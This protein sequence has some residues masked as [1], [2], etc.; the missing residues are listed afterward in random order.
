MITS[1]ELKKMPWSFLAVAALA[2]AR[3]VDAGDDQ[4]QAVLDAI[5]AILRGRA[6]KGALQ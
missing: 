5:M 2:A 1:A 4:S 3:Q 6:N